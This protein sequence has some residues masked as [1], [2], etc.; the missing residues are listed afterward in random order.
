MNRNPN[1][2]TIPKNL[3]IFLWS[4]IHNLWGA[5]PSMG[6]RLTNPVRFGRK[7]P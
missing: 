6:E 5:R 1:Y 3:V 2:S 7:Q 4:D